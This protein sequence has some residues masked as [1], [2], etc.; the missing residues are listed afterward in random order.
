MLLALIKTLRPRQWTKNLL[1]FAGL[2]FS[3][4]LTNGLMALKA[5]AGFV[6]F[7]ALSGVIYIL[8]DLADAESDKAHPRKRL[9]PI[10]SGALSVR[11]AWGGAVVIGVA[12]LGGAF[13]VGVPFGVCAGIYFVLMLAYS[14]LFKHV[15]I[16]DLMLLALGFVLRAI[17][18]VWAI[19]SVEASVL[20]TSW[21]LACT[22][23][24]ALFLA[25][26]KRRHELILLEGQAQSH[27]PVL[28]EYSPAFLDQMVSVA[29]AATII[30]YAIYATVYVHH[31]QGDAAARLDGN[32]PMI[33]TLPFV[34]YGVFRYLYQVYRRD[35]GGA[36]ETVLLTDKWLIVNIGLWGA[37]VLYILY[38]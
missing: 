35:Q 20:L 5:C 27:R 2:V 6:V 17:A 33:Y 38:A 15:V 24:L 30:C 31:P 28:E 14:F 34:V 1:L 16:L 37:T 29:T 7:C 25:I 13:S 11:A 4:N 9:R 10:A 23:F 18:G 3:H 32:S 36:P 26:C 22:F 8:N 19:R 21:F 12:A